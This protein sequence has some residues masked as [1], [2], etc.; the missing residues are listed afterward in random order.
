MHSAHISPPDSPGSQQLQQDRN[1]RQLNAVWPPDDGRKDARNMLRNKWL[2]I[3]HYSL[4]LGGSRL[5]LLVKDAR[6]LEHKV[7]FCSFSWSVGTE[8]T[9]CSCE[10]CLLL[11]PT[12]T[13]ASLQQSVNK[14]FNSIYSTRR[15]SIFSS[16]P[17]ECV[18]RSLQIVHRKIHKAVPSSRAV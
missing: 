18:W 7:S 14:L 6:S 1:H 11:Q 2:P 17:L 3:N 16:S 15:F 4:L 10:F 12:T 13:S 9:M 8:Y 5:Y